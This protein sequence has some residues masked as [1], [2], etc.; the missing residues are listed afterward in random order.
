MGVH[1][2]VCISS[3]LSFTA[4]SFSCGS[5]PVCLNSDLSAVVCTN[6]YFFFLV[7]PLIHL[8]HSVYIQRGENGT[9]I[10]YIYIYI[11]S[12]NCSISQHLTCLSEVYLKVVG[13]F[14]AL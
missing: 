10:L 11:A 1:L 14:P 13:M 3:L 4:G 5:A 2:F 8:E 7:Y 9:K 6:K 12:W